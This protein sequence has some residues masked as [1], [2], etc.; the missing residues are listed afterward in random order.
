MVLGGFT[1]L[2]VTGQGYATC[3]MDWTGVHCVC[4]IC[5]EGVLNGNERNCW[6]VDW[7]GDKFAKRGIV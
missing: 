6:Q 3:Q 4:V 5:E 1:Y 7:T 2:V